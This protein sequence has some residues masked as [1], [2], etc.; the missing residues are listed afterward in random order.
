MEVRSGVNVADTQQSQKQHF[1][2]LAVDDSLTER[3]ILERLLR[4]SS[5]KGIYIYIYTYIYHDYLQPSSTSTLSSSSS[6][7]NFT[8]IVIQG[9]LLII[10]GLNYGIIKK[11]GT[12]S[13]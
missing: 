4:E 8:R 2:V 9:C 7:S 1:H 10:W 6:S 12:H 3:K 13:M 11:I 5:C